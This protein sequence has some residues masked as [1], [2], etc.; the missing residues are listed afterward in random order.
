[1]ELVILLK[2]YA[3]YDI[4]GI[5]LNNLLSWMWIKKVGISKYIALFINLI[6]SA[7]LNFA[8]N[9]FWTFS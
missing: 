4:T 7:S 8:I 1:M 5:L 2:T 9:K 6:I 3:A